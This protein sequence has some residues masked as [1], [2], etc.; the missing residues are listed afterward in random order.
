MWWRGRIEKNKSL[1]LTLTIPYIDNI[2]EHILDNGEASKQNY[3]QW[4]ELFEEM[5]CTSDYKHLLEVDIHFRKIM[6]DNEE[7]LAIPFSDAYDKT[8]EK[9]IKVGQKLEGNRT[10][11]KLLGNSKYAH[12][13][14]TKK[15][16]FSTTEFGGKRTKDSIILKMSELEQL[17]MTNTLEIARNNYEK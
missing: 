15:V 16:K 2:F 6:V 12:K 5:V 7:C 17:G 10:I 14:K 1:L 3:E 9:A 8:Y 11:K 13:I 4:L